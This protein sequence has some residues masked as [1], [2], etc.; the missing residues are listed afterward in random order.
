MRLKRAYRLRLYVIE[1]HVKFPTLLE[2]RT[3]ALDRSKALL[4][5]K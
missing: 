1:V 4:M 3:R 2:E 5:L